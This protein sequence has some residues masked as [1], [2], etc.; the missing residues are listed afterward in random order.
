MLSP[1]ANLSELRA[2]LDGREV[3]SAEL[4]EASLG[5]AQATRDSLNAF[6]RLRPEAARAAAATADARLA[7]G[8]PRSALDGIPVAIKD[9]MVHRGEC[10]TCASRILEGFVSP[11]S[12]TAV[13]KLEAAGAVIVGSTNMDE[14]AMG[15]STEHSC[16]GPTRN[17]WNTAC[18]AGGSSG[19]S[20]AAVAAGIVP[21]ALGTDTGGSIRQPASFCGVVGIKPTYG[22]VSR[23]GLVAFAS[24]LDQIGVFARTAADAG[25]VLEVIAGHDEKDST[26]VPE[27]VPAFAKALDGD[28]SGLVVGLPREFMVE[29]GLDAGVLAAV[30]EAV[31]ELA[32]AGAEV[33]EVSLPHTEY[34]VA[35]Y[36][37]IATAEASS[38][39]AR[40]DGV[41]YGRRAADVTGLTDM[42]TRTR[43]QGFGVEVK[44]RI[45]LGTYVLSAGYYDA[46]Y[47]K[48]QQ[49]RTLLRRDFERAFAGC[50][51]IATPTSPEVAFRLGAKTDDPLR[52]YLSDIYT[53]SANLA[54]LPGISIPC[55]SAGGLPVGLQLLAAPLREATLLRV[56]DAF[57]RR[58]EHHR[59]TPPEAR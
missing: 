37:L 27:P 58:T 33:R 35:T 18:T 22:R 28:V 47:R 52:M 2:A 16:Y 53:V 51:V 29:E 44:R 48:A 49:V 36:Y 30:R 20:A 9:V 50:D 24:S 6:V 19:G 39:L 55:G 42:Y 10:T 38:N 34:A 40:Y 43:A 46:Y 8:A 32:R 4:V 11:Y 17:P 1:F 57:E 59:C 21:A 7:S 31:E 54:G 56:A 23:W 26:S 14:F 5:R 13:E 41:R 3:T 12:A 45:V 25:R 15:S